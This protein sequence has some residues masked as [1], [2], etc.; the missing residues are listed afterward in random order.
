MFDSVLV[1]K[2]DNECRPTL[3][4]HNYQLIMVALWNRADHYI[5]GQW[6]LLFMA[7]LCNRTDHYI[8]ALLFL[9]SS[10]FFFLLYFPRLISSVD[11]WMSAILP[12]MVWP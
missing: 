5:F 6:F 4:A 8:F 7:A 10:S 1:Y 2:L 9:L 11:D 3:E 12:H